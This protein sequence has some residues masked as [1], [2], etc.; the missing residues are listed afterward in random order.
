MGLDQYVFMQPEKKEDKSATWWEAP[1]ESIIADEECIQVM[2]WRKHADL[3]GWM[4]K[5]YRS[6]GGEE[7]FNCVDVDLTE[8]DILR[9]QEENYNLN[10]TTGFFFGESH[11]EDVEKT[12]EFLSKALE[13]LRAD[14][15][16]F[17][18]SWW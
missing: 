8:E 11:W 14:K 9:L 17:Y 5:L 15:K 4:E 16:L 3:Q 7:E 6:K 2:Y 10:P 12:A 18:T 1:E 13:L